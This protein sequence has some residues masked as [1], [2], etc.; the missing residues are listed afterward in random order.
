MGLFSMT[1]TNVAAKFPA[2]ILKS[3]KLVM[4]TVTANIAAVARLENPRRPSNFERSG[5]DRIMG[6]L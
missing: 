1:T 4:V 2:V 5:L 3:K 6:G